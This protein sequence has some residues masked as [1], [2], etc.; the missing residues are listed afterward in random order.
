VNVIRHPLKRFY[1]AGDLH[2]VTFSCYRRRPY[3]GT[4]HARNCFVRVLDQVRSRYRFLLLA[5]VVMPEHVHLLIGE[6]AKG[7]PSKVLQALKQGV[8]GSLRRN[9]FRL[10]VATAAEATKPSPVWQRRFY[11]FNVRSAQKLREKI[12]YMHRN[13]VQRRLVQNPEGWPWSS[14]LHYVKGERG[15][16]SIDTLKKPPVQKKIRTL[17]NQR[18][19]HPSGFSE[20]DW[21]IWSST[22]SRMSS[23]SL[24]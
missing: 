1:G 15:L 5:Y 21:L 22:N 18:V 13:P 19:R 11:D 2:F 17:E 16:I 23:V 14:W 3:L 8:S 20:P 4:V 24:N 9:K 6:P 12:D 10:C 7:N